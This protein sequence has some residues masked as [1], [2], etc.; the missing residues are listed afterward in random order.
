MVLSFRLSPPHPR[1]APPHPLI[2]A[3]VSRLTHTPLRALTADAQLF[4]G[5]GPATGPS[6]RSPMRLIYNRLH[7]AP[8]PTPP[9]RPR[10]V[11]ILTT[12]RRYYIYTHTPS[13]LISTSIHLIF[14]CSA[15][16][17]VAAR[18]CKI[19]RMCFRWNFDD[20]SAGSWRWKSGNV[21][22]VRCPPSAEAAKGN[23]CVAAVAAT[24]AGES[25]PAGSGLQ[26]PIIRPCA[27]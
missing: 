24:L 6:A 14:L 8:L 11:Y 13:D 5:A 10:R 7:H 1:L 9:P 17:V 3:P 26:A 27:S 25:P 23:S 16:A 15:R 22:A 18:G 21:S 2:I 4:A 12:T 19:R 20:A